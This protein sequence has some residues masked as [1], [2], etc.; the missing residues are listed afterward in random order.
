MKN[1]LGLLI[2]FGLLGFSGCGSA[3]PKKDPELKR[4]VSFVRYLCS[5]RFLRKSAFISSFPEKKPTQFVSY[6]F[7]EMGVSEW[8]STGDP[9]EE[10]QLK[11]I[12]V[13]V[14][15]RNVRITNRLIKGAEKQVVLKGDDQ[16]LIVIVEGY[17]KGSG[18]PVFIDKLRFKP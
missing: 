18:T 6:L 3:A 11:S 7:S 13:P 1:L 9:F 12:G 14:P 17:L 16:E 4:A 15:P 10:E 8:V 5:R 2:V